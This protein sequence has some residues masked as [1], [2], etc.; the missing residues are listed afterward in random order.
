MRK[1]D[2]PPISR[3]STEGV[4]Q[5][6]WGEQKE[7]AYVTMNQENS[8]RHN[9]ERLLARK[10]AWTKTAVFFEHLWLKLW[11]LFI[12]IALYFIASLY[13]LWDNISPLAHR[14]TLALFVFAALAALYPLLSLRWPG[15]SEALKRLDRNSTLPH[16][17][18]QAF[19]DHL[20]PDLDTDETR[21]LWT[22]F[23]ERLV[24]KIRHLRVPFPQPKTSEKDPYAIRML[25]LVAVALGLFIQSGNVGPLLSKGVKVPPM[26]D[27][28][29][30]RIDAWVTPPPYT[31]Q[32]PFL[33]TNGAV[34][35]TETDGPKDIKVPQNAILTIRINGKN[36]DRL[37]I[38]TGN[39]PLQQPDIEKAKDTP[40]SREFT[41]KLEKAGRI[42]L[43]A[44]EVPITN[45][46]FNII[47]DNPP[48]IG[49][50]EPPQKARS[51][52]LKLAYKVVDDYGVISAK[53][54][55][56]NVTINGR[57]IP[58]DYPEDQK[59]LGDPAIYPLVLPDLVTRQGEGETFKDLTRHPW[60][61]LSATLYL[62]ATDEGGNTSNSP[63]I[64][65]ILPA[66]KFTQPLAKNIIRLQKQLVVS[67]HTSAQ[68]ARSILAL[69]ADK[70][71]FKDDLSLYLGMRVAA[72]RLYFSRNRKEKE[73]VSE[74]LYELARRAEDGD[75]SRAEQE[76]R[77]AQEALRDALKNNASAEEI[78]KRIDELREAMQKYMQA[79]AKK[80]QNQQAQQQQGDN[81]KIS[82][83]DY[84]DMLKTIEDLAKSG[85]KDLA[86][87]MLSQ[88]QKMLENT[89]TGQNQ[90]NQEQ[91][92]DAKNLKELGELLRL[93]Q[94]LMDKTFQRQRKSE[95]SSELGQKSNQKSQQEQ[96]SKGQGNKGDSNQRGHKPSSEP[97]EEQTL[98]AQQQE[99]KEK[100]EQLMKQMRRGNDTHSL[101]NAGK[102]M[103]RAQEML[104][105]NQLQGALSEEGKALDQ[106]RRGIEKMAQKMAQ[107]NGRGGGK[108]RQGEDP[109][110]RN[111]GNMG[112]DTSN[113]T[114]VPDKID[115]QR[116]REILRNL[117][118]KLSDPNRRALEL[119]YF[120]RL[121][122]R[123]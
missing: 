5:A 114:K 73:E 102:S 106:L 104:Q 65:L 60:A 98:A 30:I 74:L 41:V 26:L 105:N 28:R 21:T 90:N 122:K 87:Q 57:K 79:L 61:G 72:N 91:S 4:K 40:T 35:K 97:G 32:A 75:L 33:V 120:E 63:S 95:K 62:S 89:Q 42:S 8:P 66:Y 88:L 58:E 116:A 20:S 123:F 16:Q 100:L 117:Q 7:T 78:Q 71:S 94:E 46:K 44:D 54:N 110:G 112:L 77:A 85:S 55:I 80:Q 83:K 119:D 39:N 45:W 22:L 113:S 52:A 1:L 14:F 48:V 6:N 51:G 69:T 99:L 84:E 96:Q 11:P 19:K 29:A 82:P 27:T 111:E 18:A 23:K 101:D 118:E 70:Q 38:N 67:P 81:N 56:V 3:T 15:E 36:T 31:N 121:L 47:P 17:P 37:S 25:L 43:N 92:E 2:I 10:L 9:G 108:K 115:I 49:L 34:T 68:T 93:Q 109:L 86:Q 12:V 107:Q 76:L 50:I 64:E 59:P 53:A 24:E 103:Q 13:G